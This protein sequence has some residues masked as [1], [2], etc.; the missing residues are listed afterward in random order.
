MTVQDNPIAL[1]DVRQ[2][3]DALDAELVRLLVRRA[4]LALQAKAQ[5]KPDAVSI[6]AQDRVAEVLRRVRAHAV[7]GGGDP[8]LIQR[9]YEFIIQEY[10]EM[11]LKQPVA[12][13][14]AR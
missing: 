6:A 2:Q 12:G 3:I 1:A 4:G 13:A 10:T 8:D 14:E 5:K 9:I 11:Q 7:S